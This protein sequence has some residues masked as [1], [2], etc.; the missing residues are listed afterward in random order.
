MWITCGR[1]VYKIGPCGKKTG[2]FVQFRQKEVLKFYTTDMKGF[3]DFRNYGK[4]EKAG[5][6]PYNT[7]NACFCRILFERSH[8]WLIRYFSTEVTQFAPS[9]AAVMI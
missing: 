4:T 5:S 2:F 9:A 3:S 1:D 8:Q 7:K 6:S